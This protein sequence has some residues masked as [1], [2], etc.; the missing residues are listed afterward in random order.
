MARASNRILFASILELQELI[1]EM[2]S[3]DASLLPALYS[4][5][6]ERVDRY[7][8]GLDS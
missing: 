4:I 7:E 8:R 6:D 3:K 1:M 5:L 2:R